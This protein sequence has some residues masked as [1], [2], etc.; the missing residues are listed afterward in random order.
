MKHFSIT[1]LVV[2]T[3][4]SCSRNKKYRTKTGLVYQVQVTDTTK[5]MATMGTTAKINYAQAVGDSVISTTYNRMPLYYM[6]MPKMSP[7]NPLEVLDYGMHEGDSV[8][9]IQRIDSMMSKGIFKKKPEWMK[10]DDQWVTQLKV[11][12]VFQNDSLLQADKQME[13]DRVTK[14]Q[15]QLGMTR[16]K[17]YLDSNHI[18]ALAHDKMYVQVLQEGIGELLDSSKTVRM[19]FE[20][21]TLKGKTINSTIDTTFHNVGKKEIILGRHTLPAMIEKYLI[22]QKAGCIVIVYTPAVQLFGTQPEKQGVKIDDDICIWLKT[23]V[24]TNNNK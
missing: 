1:L 14:L 15:T 20:L 11:E 18:D 10:K 16:I 21:K 3:I 4:V 22:T 9:V 12:K 2:L 8:T 23:E 7:Y 17:E 13:S 24:Q 6:V 19:D 5:P